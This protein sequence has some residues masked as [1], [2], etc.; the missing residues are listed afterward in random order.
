[1]FVVTNY[2]LFNAVESAAMLVI[3][4]RTDQSDNSLDFLEHGSSSAF[5]VIYS[6]YRS[7]LNTADYGC[8]SHI[9][10]RKVS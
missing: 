2:R 5:A 4:S 10:E 3:L 1:M 6:N 8:R 9:N 7:G